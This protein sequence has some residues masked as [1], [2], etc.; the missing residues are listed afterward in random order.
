M[1]VSLCSL[2]VMHVVK[3]D[4]VANCKAVA[5]AARP[6]TLQDLLQGC[7]SCKAVRTWLLMLQGIL[8]S[9]VM[10]QGC[11]CCQAVDAANMLQGC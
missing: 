9:D 5:S 2:L 10:W 4:T 6:V 11:Q 3:R 8:A 1:P 7:Q